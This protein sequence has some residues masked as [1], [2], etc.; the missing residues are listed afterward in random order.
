MRSRSQLASR[1][2]YALSWGLCACAPA[3]DMGGA[4]DDASSSGAAMDEDSA[5]STGGEAMPRQCRELA[6]QIAAQWS[7]LV[8][9]DT[10]SGGALLRATA[11]GGALV[12]GDASFVRLDGT[13][14]PRA[15]SWFGSLHVYAAAVATDDEVWVGGHDGDPTIA[16]F[17]DDGEVMRGSRVQLDAS[18]YITD[19]LPD[20]TGALALTVGEGVRLQHVDTAMTFGPP[21]LLAD[22]VEFSSAQLHADGLV[23]VATL[24]DAVTV[25]LLFD[26]MGMQQW[27]AELTMTNDLQVPWIAARAAIGDAVYL[28]LD[29]DDLASSDSPTRWLLGLDRD[30]GTTRFELPI[31]HDEIVATSCGSLYRVA[32]GPTI[33]L[34]EHDAS[35]AVLA[36]AELVPPTPPQ[37]FARGEVRALAMSPTGVLLVRGT[38]VRDDDTTLEWVAAY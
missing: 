13:G 23:S 20:D 33:A 7:T 32:S 3:V 9:P 11:D 12:V 28:A 27:R 5:S 22:E 6:P 31:E 29:V 24:E 15:V 14:A 19:V 26:A 4:D 25:V 30:D 18:E 2:G 35:G 10:L 17:D 34:V 37:G 21:I 1:C 8:D 36:E 38:H 16:R